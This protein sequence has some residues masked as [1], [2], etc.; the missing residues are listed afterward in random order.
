MRFDR[1]V[2]PDR[3]QDPW[4]EAFDDL[5]AVALRPGVQIL[6]VGSGRQPTI[7]PGCRPP[8]SHYVGL[9]VSAEELR[10]AASG[11]YDE[12]WVLDVATRVPELENRFDLIL[13]YQVLEHVKPL[14][15]VLDNVYA[16]LRPGGRFVALLS[17]K[18]SA[19]GVINSVI[20]QRLGV[21]AMEKLI[22]RPPDTVF[23]AYYHRCWYGAMDRMLSGW[24][25][26]EIRPLYRGASYLSFSGPLQRLYVGYENW[27]ANGDHRNLATHYLLAADR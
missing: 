1:P 21:W 14:D 8:G 24:S 26:R 15:E 7:G 13:S 23:P 12:T 25:A 11:S 10:L 20:P 9:D 3:Y 27:A 18:F 19:F 17:G 2:L 5:A 6:D 4:R 22:G 16:Y